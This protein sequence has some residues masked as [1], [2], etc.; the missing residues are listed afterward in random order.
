MTS[1]VPRGGGRCAVIAA[2]AF[3][4]PSD[5]TAYVSG[6]LVANST[7]AGSV[8]P[9]QWSLRGE[10]SAIEVVRVRLQ[11]STTTASAATFRVHLYESSPTPAN[12]DN[13]A[14]ATDVAGYLGYAEVVM[15]AFTDDAYGVGVPGTPIIAQA[16]TGARLICG[17]L[18]ARGAYV[19]KPQS[20]RW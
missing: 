20:E 9:I 8:V 5:T 19:V 14:W 4:R 15:A 2:A 17:L 16:A 7:T 1:S 3:A 13:S 6:D 11:K 12:G 10:G 18:E